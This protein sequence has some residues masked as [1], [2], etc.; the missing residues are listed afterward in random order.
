MAD[1]I[2]VRGVLAGAYV[3]GG[4]RKC[5]PSTQT[6][7]THAVAVDAEGRDIKVLCNRVALD[8][9]CDVVVGGEPSCPTCARRNLCRRCRLPRE[10]S[11]DHARSCTWHPSRRMEMP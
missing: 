5:P 9:L 4:R 8:S 1:R 6:F 7:L 11:D 2:E 3:S 10:V